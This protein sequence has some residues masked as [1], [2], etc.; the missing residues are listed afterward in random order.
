MPPY[1]CA[2]F[3]RVFV[4]RVRAYIYAHT[5]EIN[6]YFIYY[7]IIYIRNNVQLYNKAKKENQRTKEK[8]RKRKKQ[9][10]KQR[11][12]RKQKDNTQRTKKAE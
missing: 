8:E 1:F 4:V 10:S 3:F 9:E 12:T 5:N 7:I 6:R 11:K 2:L